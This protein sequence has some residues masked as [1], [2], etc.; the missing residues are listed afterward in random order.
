M[1]SV[2]SWDCWHTASDTEFESSEGSFGF[3]HQA[4]TPCCF[5]RGFRNISDAYMCFHF[6]SII[7]DTKH[8]RWLSW[9]FPFTP[10]APLDLDSLYSCSCWCS[11]KVTWGADRGGGRG[12]AHYQ[13]CLMTRVADTCN[14]TKSER[15]PKLR[16]VAPTR[17]VGKLASEIAVSVHLTC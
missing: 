3:Q 4:R 15:S 12:P 6:L 11:V 2:D 10:S 1:F 17:L 7:T 5:P 16:A 8:F 13:Q 14:T 9:A